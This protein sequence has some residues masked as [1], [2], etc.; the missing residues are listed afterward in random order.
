MVS[1]GPA[2]NDPD[3]LFAGQNDP[4]LS[5]NDGRSPLVSSSSP[6]SGPSSVA[7]PSSSTDAPMVQPVLFAAER[8]ALYAGLME[9]TL[10]VDANDVASNADRGSVTSRAIALGLAQRLKYTVTAQ[11]GAGQTAGNDFEALCASFVRNTF[12]QLGH[13]RPGLWKVEQYRGQR[14]AGLAMYEQY[15]HLEALDAA[16]R[17]NP[18]LA[19]ALGSDYTIK[20]DVVVWRSPEPDSTINASQPLVDASVATRSPLRLSVNQRPILHASLS[21]KWTL[22]SD[23]AQNARSEALNLIRNR[24]G[25]LPHIAVITAEPLPSR[26]ASIALGTG[27]VD[28]VYHFALHELQDTVASLNL[29]DAQDMLAVM[30]EGR[31]LKD[32]SDLPLDISV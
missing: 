27:D 11:R 2:D 4:A 32:I 28:C 18:E 1:D 15:A 14:R 13:I 19:A 8:A 6:M 20:P 3:D 31:R 29:P 5:P 25:H 10:T 12:L 7:G 24:K 16:A 26:L 22:R 30:V 9:S 17:N 23:R 21:C